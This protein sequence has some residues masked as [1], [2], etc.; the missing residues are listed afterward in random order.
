MGQLLRAALLKIW[1][2]LQEL[3]GGGRVEVSWPTVYD[4]ALFHKCA[5]LPAAVQVAKSF[6]NRRQ[7][8]QWL[9]P[10]KCTVCLEI[11]IHLRQVL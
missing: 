4:Q 7:R 8:P 11:H 10:A 6:Y 5:C 9:Q 2:A 3:G 1:L